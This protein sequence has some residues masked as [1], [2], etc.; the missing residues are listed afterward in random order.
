MHYDAIVVGGGFSGAMAAMAMAREGLSVLLCEKSG[1]LGGAA[2][3]NTVLPFMEYRMT[4]NAKRIRL[5]RGLFSEL[6]DRLNVYGAL[7]AR[8]VIYNEEYLKIVFDEMA[9][10]YGVKVLY[11]ATLFDVD[12]ADRLLRSLSFITASGKLTFTADYAVDATGDALL[13]HLAGCPYRVGRAIDEKCQPMTLCFR[14]SGIDCDAFF[15]DLARLNTLWAEEKAAGIIQNP[16]ENLLV[17]RTAWKG[18][19]HFNAT[20]ILSSPL[21]PFEK[22]DAERMA[23]RQMLEI[24]DFLKRHAP[25][26]QNA[27]LLS[28]ASEIGVRESRMIE[29]LYTVTEEDILERRK[30]PDAIAAGNYGVDIHSPDGSGTRRVKMR[31]GTFYT[32][33]YRATVPIGIDNLLVVGRAISSTHEAQSAY[34]IMP[35]VA[36]IGEGAGI[37]LA[38]CH[39]QKIK[40]AAL[41]TPTLA[42]A[43]DA[44]DLV[45]REE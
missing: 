25:S 42:A 7:D 1:S 22:S 6:L 32:I 26:C 16:R 11:H 12:V 35:N 44:Y 4:K 29:G 9:E 10:A 14:L 23:R 41:D 13:A 2:T 45:E 15:A 33:P 27:A 21:D 17:F 31:D 40:T 24:L 3:V 38:L 5:N 20:R 43:I 19:L 34:R 37:A 18:V 36:A 28:S 39:K 30:F 8:E